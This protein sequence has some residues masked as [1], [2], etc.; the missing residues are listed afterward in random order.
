MAANME[1]YKMF[2]SKTKNPW[3]AKG[4]KF[5]HPNATN[6][7]LFHLS[8][9]DFPVELVDLSQYDPKFANYFLLRNTV[10]GEVLRQCKGR[11]TPMQSQN[12]FDK[13]TQLGNITDIGAIGNGEKVFFSIDA[14]GFSIGEEN[15]HRSFINAIL[16]HDGTMKVTLGTGDFRIECQ[17]T[18]LAWKRSL[19]ES[20]ILQA[21]QTTTCEGKI[22]GWVKA[23]QE[24]KD[25]TKSLHENFVT[26]ARKVFSAETQSKIIQA[27]FDNKENTRSE[28]QQKMLAQIIGDNAS[29]VSSDLRNTGYDLINGVTYYTSHVS[30]IK[31][32]TER[33]E[34]L[35]F[36][37]AQKFAEKAMLILLQY[38]PDE[39]LDSVISTTQEISLIDRAIDQMSETPLLDDILSLA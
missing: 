17:N 32:G 36:G 31:Q 2:A 5:V 26:L 13:I 14:G 7:E 8:G 39:L 3:W 18:F 38:Q 6:E 12:F 37:S 27:I 9:A 30:P 11:L 22:N 16:P 23:F 21:K 20:D 24:M 34:A 4:D 29:K 28:N 1:K 19:N 15:T 25:E 10:N 35:A 33:S